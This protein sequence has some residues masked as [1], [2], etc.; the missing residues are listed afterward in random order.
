MSD[1]NLQA[2]TRVISTLQSDNNHSS[3]HSCLLRFLSLP[4]SIA[5]CAVA[6]RPGM[7]S[8]DRPAFAG[9]TGSRPACPANRRS[10]SQIFRQNDT[11][12]CAAACHDSLREKFCTAGMRARADFAIGRLKGPAFDPL[13]N[14]APATAPPLPDVQCKKAQYQCDDLHSYNIFTVSAIS[15]LTSS[16][17]FAIRLPRTGGPQ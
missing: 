13:A 9:G 8:I 16:R 10:V 6:C 7:L 3:L 2:R 17:F 14:S 15:V 12:K 5:G 11:P 4:A 1:R